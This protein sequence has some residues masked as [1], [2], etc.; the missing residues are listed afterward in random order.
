MDVQLVL[1]ADLTD[2]PVGATEDEFGGLIATSFSESQASNDGASV[3]GSSGH[4]T[5]AV[6]KRK[7]RSSDEHGP[8]KRT[9]EER[10]KR[11]A[12]VVLQHS[13]P[14]NPDGH[15]TEHQYPSTFPRTREQSRQ[16]DFS[17]GLQNHRTAAQSQPEN[18]RGTF[19]AF[20]SRWQ[21]A[22]SSIWTSCSRAWTDMSSCIVSVRES[23]ESSQGNCARPVIS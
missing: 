4:N 20:V 16:D 13:C 7:G 21:T 5:Q 11:T 23:Q 14:L 15:E 10:F 6:P 3:G 12:E 8:T 17:D 9:R 2:E 19:K 18:E 1:S 22:S